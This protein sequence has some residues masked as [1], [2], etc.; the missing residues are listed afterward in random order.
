MATQFTNYT[1]DGILN[2]Y[3]RNTQWSNAGRT[4]IQVGLHTA[5]PTAAGSDAA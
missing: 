5:D 4:S 2:H 1:K 3:F